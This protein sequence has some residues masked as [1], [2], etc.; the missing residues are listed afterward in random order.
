[1]WSNEKKCSDL[2]RIRILRR[3]IQVTEKALQDMR[4]EGTCKNLKPKD[5]GK[6]EGPGNFFVLS[7]VYTRTDAGGGSTSQLLPETLKRINSLNSN[8]HRI[9][10]STLGKLHYVKLSVFNF[11]LNSGTALP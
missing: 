6:K 5:C 3:D 10:V 9:I 1:M 11:F 7:P 2:A 4:K 8:F